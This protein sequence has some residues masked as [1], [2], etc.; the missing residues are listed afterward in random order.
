[1]SD[2]LNWASMFRLYQAIGIFLLV[3]LWVIGAALAIGYFD[4]HNLFAPG[5]MIHTGI[6]VVCVGCTITVIKPANIRTLFAAMGLV[7]TK[8]K[9]YFAA[10]AMASLFWSGDYWL[11][12]QLFLNDGSEDALELQ[13]AA[14]LNPISLIVTTSFLAPVAEE[15]L[16]RG[17]LLRALVDKIP[18]AWSILISSLLFAVIHFSAND[19]LTLFIVAVG[20]AILTLKSASIWPAILAHIINNSVTFCYFLTI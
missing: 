16:F 13:N 6:I 1:M 8:W 19:F 4:W 17:I 10:I 11:Q 9:Y 18:A 3:S 7:A 12:S 5:L 15:I 2:T 14:K 20:Y